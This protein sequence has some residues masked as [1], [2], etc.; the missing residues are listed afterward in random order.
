[1]S[2]IHQTDTEVL[3]FYRSARAAV[4]ASSF[5]HEIDW[6]T[7]QD[8]VTLGEMDFLREA[9]WVVINSGFRESVAR[10]KFNHIS[11]SFGDWESARYIV[12]NRDTCISCA[13][14]GFGHG[15]KIRAIADIA[16][17]VESYGFDRLKKD[18]LDDPITTLQR[19]PFIGP[20]TVWHLAKNI[21][22]D[23]A[24]PDRHLVRAAYGFG[25]DCV[26]SFCGEIAKATGER[27][28]V[29]D[30]VI[31]RYCASLHKLY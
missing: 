23:V 14:D 17:Q 26:Q 6:Q 18:I 28:G 20:V 25:F 15:G 10:R 31:W 9:A 8:L 16:E 11:L 13:L 27:V 19:L 5:R 12:D 21:G 2:L 30:I 4:A 1:M 3:D 7:D 22:C 29:V 24:K